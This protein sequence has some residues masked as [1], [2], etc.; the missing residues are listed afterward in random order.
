MFTTSKTI[1]N[2]TALYMSTRKKNKRDYKCPLGPPTH[3]LTLAYATIKTDMRLH[4]TLRLDAE[5]SV[6][7]PTTFR[8]QE[9]WHDNND[10]LI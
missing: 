2:R 3:K 10:P 1:L 4:P 6:H 8:I 9:S 5:L 7:S